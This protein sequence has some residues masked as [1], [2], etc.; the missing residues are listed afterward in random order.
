[1]QSAAAPAGPGYLSGLTPLEIEAARM[2]W[3]TK[4]FPN[5]LK[6]LQY[7]ESIGDQLQRAGSLLLGYGVKVAAR[8]RAKAATDAITAAAG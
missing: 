5:E 7:L 1:M 4:K 2:G 8:A 3:A 6:R